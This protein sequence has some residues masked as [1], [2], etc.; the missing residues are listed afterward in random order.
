M[1]T[2]DIE[3]LHTSGVYPKR[4]LEIVR[5]SG[6]HVWDANGR[7]YIDCVAGQGVVLVGHCNPAVVE[8]IRAQAE[9]LISCPE[10]FYN[11]QR[12]RALALLVEEAP[13]GLTRVFLCNSGTEAF[14]AA[15]K[16]ARL[17]TGRVG[18]V[19]A[20]RGFH[21]RTFGALSATWES[22]Y[23]DPFLPLVPGFQ[24]VPFDDLD[25]M[26]AAVSSETAAVLLE[27]VQGEGGVRPSS[28]GYLAG[29]REICDQHGALLIV[30]EIQTGCGR[31]GRMWACQHDG[32]IPDLMCVGK[33]IAGGVPMGAVLFGSRIPELPQGAHG[34][35]FGGNPLAAAAAVATLRYIREHD[36]PRRA[37][38]LGEWLLGCL[39]E[40]PSRRVREVRGL[41]L[42]VGIELK[43][44][45]KPHLLALQ[46]QGV[47]ALPATS[48]VL[49]LLP[50]LV[51]EQA[52]LE[53][54]VHA[55]DATLSA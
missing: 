9:R 7:E 34:S 20:M 40:I 41:G 44:K 21:G 14:E 28:P 55:I 49:R 4:D 29:V 39:R 2:M 43:E 11:D 50:P 35:T 47:L 53:R 3:R 42:M 33:G 48:T 12:A 10:V 31:T 23:R 16:F 38:Q 6:A 37:A 25:R 13:Q 19:A 1:S 51:I 15:L 36:L 32:V 22:K 45:V 52:D 8:A 26:S 46:E 17:A 24:H 30:D 54:V 27:V 5:G 18:F